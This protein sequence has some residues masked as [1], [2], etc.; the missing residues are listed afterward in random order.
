MRT[1]NNQALECIHPLYTSA[2]AIKLL[3]DLKDP[4]TRI[5]LADSLSC[6]SRG[7]VPSAACTSVLNKLN[8]PRLPNSIPLAGYRLA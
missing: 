3:C 6:N 7:D 4:L 5:S 8:Q 1:A 2:T